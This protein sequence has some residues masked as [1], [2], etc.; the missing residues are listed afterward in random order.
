MQKTKTIQIGQRSFTLKELN[1]RQVWQLLDSEGEQP[2]LDRCRELLKLGCPEL[3]TEVLLDMYPSEIEELWQ[4]FEEVNAA[5]LGI[6][7]LVGMDRALIDAVKTAVASSIG[8]F[9]HSSSPATVQ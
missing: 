3:D 9:A 1:T 7:R 4:G 8:R 6:V 2:M 5:F